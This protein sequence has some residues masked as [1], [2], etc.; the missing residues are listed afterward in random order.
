MWV[1]KKRELLG[2]NKITL[3]YKSVVFYT[4]AGAY[5][6]ILKKRAH[7]TESMGKKILGCNKRD[8]SL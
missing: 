4:T 6:I 8:V 5:R 1:Y 7:K 2:R 3:F